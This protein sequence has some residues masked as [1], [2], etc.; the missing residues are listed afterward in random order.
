VQSNRFTVHF[1]LVLACLCPGLAAAASPQQGL[2]T[3]RPAAVLHIPPSQI[4]APG[5]SAPAAAA[6][7]P[8]ADQSGMSAA[9]YAAAKRLAAT[10]PLAEPADQ[11]V[12]I[13]GRL[14]GS[15]AP[16]A[17]N[18]SSRSLTPP[19]TTLSTISTTFSG[20]DYDTGLGTPPDTIVAKS[21]YRVLEAVNSALRLTNT[22][23]SVTFATTT[24]GAFFNPA[25]TYT[26]PKVFFDQNAANLRFYVVVEQYPTFSPQTSAI[27]LAVSRTPNPSDFSSSSWCTYQINAAYTP[28]GGTLSFADSPSLGV[29]ADSVL[30]T[31]NQYTF[32][33]DS[34]EISPLWVFDKASLSNNATS[35][36]TLT[37]Y[38]FQ[39]AAANDTTVF[40]LQPTQHYTS[41]SSF[42]GV[43]NP[44][45]LVSNHFL[46]SGDRSNIYSVW[47]LSNVSG[48]NPQLTSVNV[49][50]L[51]NRNYQI[52]PSAEQK[53]GGQV[54][55]TGDARVKQVAGIGDSL[56]AA[57]S[58][59][60]L[61]GSTNQSCIRVLRFD[62]GEDGSGNLTASIGQ[63]TTFAGPEHT[64]YW[65]PG[66][67][68]NSAQQTAV[69]FQFSS[70]DNDYLS[71]AFT[72]KDAS[73]ST[74][75]AATT[76]ATGSCTSGSHT[77]D[78]VGAQTNPNDL[79]SFWLAGERSALNSQ[80]SCQ[81]GTTIVNVTP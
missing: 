17:T 12:P 3:I 72:V 13:G 40:T 15:A 30:V 39:P 48:G 9:D 79:T 74:Y 37:S 1:T 27:W 76:F 67:A 24:T 7:E 5:S 14:Q 52:P 4:P 46:N 22:S 60:C 58:T 32:S 45:Y 47:R 20:L 62:V 34:F 41:P 11:I 59:N 54:T 38:F 16:G 56:W 71:A 10:D 70:R 42:G 35:C 31:T 63:Q 18:F 49:T 43:S 78:Y 69:A 26:D 44:A 68:A 66:I 29:G 73:A 33:T 57:Q 65:M 50:A 2:I 8:D 64:Y 77:G 23:G 55:N 36:P 19:I 81:W 53:G 6:P 75:P 51:S 61:V 80:N 21:G 28:S 25:K